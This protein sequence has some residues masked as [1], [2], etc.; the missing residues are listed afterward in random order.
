MMPELQDTQSSWLIKFS[1]STLVLSLAYGAKLY[2]Y[3]KPQAEEKKWLDELK[4]TEMAQWSRALA[5][6]A[7]GQEVDG[8]YSQDQRGGS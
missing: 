6:L 4:R 2:S 3:Q 7:E 5:A 1:C 8:S